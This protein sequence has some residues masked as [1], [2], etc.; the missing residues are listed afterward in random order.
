MFIQGWQV[1]LGCA[2]CIWNNLC[3]A[4]YTGKKPISAVCW[5]MYWDFIFLRFLAY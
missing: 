1:V 5:E 2:D 3:T 4:K